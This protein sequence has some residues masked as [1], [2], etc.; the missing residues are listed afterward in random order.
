[1]YS[2]REPAVRSVPFN[3]KDKKTIVYMKIL[4]RTLKAILIICLAPVVFVSMVFGTLIIPFGLIIIDAIRYILIGHSNLALNY[5]GGDWWFEPA[6]VG[7]GWVLSLLEQYD[8]I[9]RLDKK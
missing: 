6:D 8:R 9:F 2:G 4:F 3:T 7:F 5:L 1:M